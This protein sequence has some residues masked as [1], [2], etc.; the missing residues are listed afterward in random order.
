MPLKPSYLY[1]VVPADGRTNFGPIGLDGG[2]VRTVSDGGIG[3]VTS[4]AD[5]ILFSAISPEK[6]LRY[7]AQH[8]RVLEQV[9]LESSVIPLKFGTYADN[10]GHILKILDCGRNQF[11]GALERYAGKVEVDLA[12]FWTDLKSV[13]AEIGRDENVVSMRARI[14]N[15]P[16]ATTEQRVRLGQLVKKLL[17]ERRDALAAEL[18]AALRS[19]CS[20]VVINPATEDVMIL[21][22]AILAQRNDQGQLDQAIHELNLHHENRLDFR[23]VGPLPPYSFAMAEIKTIQA[24][25]LDAARRL[26]ELGESASLAE[27]KGAYRRLLQ[28]VHPD[29]NTEAWATDRLKDI[30]A[31]YELL[32]EYALNFRHTLNAVPEAPVIVTVRSLDDLRARTRVPTRRG[33]PGRRE[34]VGAEA[35]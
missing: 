35:M 17:D 21:S 26:L 9:M 19:K 32:E 13:L 34:C 18:V 33:Q 25:R 8:Q 31:A 23:C 1:G 22:V 3:I 28:E 6:T 20:G 2:E 30:S 29:R 16:E 12:V 15:Q 11:A 10:D 5:R 14:G 4:Q 7:L 24:S 27:I